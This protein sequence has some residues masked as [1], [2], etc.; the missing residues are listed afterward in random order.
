MPVT[1]L[2]RKRLKIGIIDLI[3]RQATKSVYARIVNPNY[4]AIMPQVVAVWAEQLGH[5]VHYLTFTGFEDLYRDLPQDVDVIFISTFTQNAYTAYSIANLF[6]ERGVVTVLGGPH[7]RAFAEDARYHFDYVLG[8][9]DKELI[10]DLLGDFRPHPGEG[11]MLS[12]T[13]QIRSVPGIQ[14]RWR[15]VEQN[16]KKTRIVHVVP[17]I[18]SLGCPYTCNFCIDSKIDYQPLPFDQ[19]REDLDFLQRQPKPHR[20]QYL[21]RRP[22]R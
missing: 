6:R 22:G 9:T 2:P 20:Q 10:R 21:L 15:F 19:I 5:E 4:T 8:L 16:L 12:A 13:Q 18:G 11:V 17:M 1:S 14:E 3:A 7:A